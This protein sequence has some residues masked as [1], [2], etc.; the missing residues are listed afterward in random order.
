MEVSVLSGRRSAETARQYCGASR[1]GRLANN[2]HWQKNNIFFSEFLF[3]S[4]MALVYSVEND[5]K[6]FSDIQ[7]KNGLFGKN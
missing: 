5:L 4:K 7:A 2:K 3:R 6:Y 1:V